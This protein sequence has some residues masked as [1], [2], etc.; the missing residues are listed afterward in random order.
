MTS[1][2]SKQGVS[3]LFYLFDYFYSNTSH[4]IWRCDS[5]NV[6]LRHPVITRHALFSY[7]SSMSMCVDL[8]HTGAV[9]SST[10]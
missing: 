9:H 8:S 10:E 7:V 3:L 1:S 4:D 5:T 2:V 6:G